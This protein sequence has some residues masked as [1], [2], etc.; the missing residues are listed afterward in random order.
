ML[1]LF[2]Q[3]Y[4]MKHYFTALKQTKRIGV[5]NFKSGFSADELHFLDCLIDKKN[6]SID[7]E[8]VDGKIFATMMDFISIFQNYKP[9]KWEGIDLSIFLPRFWQAFE[10]YGFDFI[11]I[12][13]SQIN[14]YHQ[15]LKETERL[16]VKIQDFEDGFSEEE[17]YLLNCLTNRVE[18]DFSRVQREHIATIANFA[19][20]FE[21]YDVRSWEYVDY[22]IFLPCFWQAYQQ[23]GL[24][25]TNVHTS[26]LTIADLFLRKYHLGISVEHY[27][28]NY[29]DQ[30]NHHEVYDHPSYISWG[31]SLLED[32][33]YS[34]KLYEFPS[35]DEIEDKQFIL[36]FAKEFEMTIDEITSDVEDGI[37][38]G[39]EVITNI[40]IQDVTKIP[41]DLIRLSYSSE[42]KQLYILYEEW[43]NAE[44]RLQL[45]LDILECIEKEEKQNENSNNH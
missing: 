22:S 36:N 3:Q 37:C 5:N 26:Q 18:I 34:S 19:S 41:D 2:E 16:G 40:T 23:H 33:G 6:T 29:L 28:P 42:E 4:R 35:I 8:K 44:H 31:D 32:K 17:I 10:K 13:A 24:A 30:M 39:F 38:N 14:Y 43:F 45:I 15:A 9:M 11:Y 7:I 27:Y 21:E 20:F 25:F 12:E 1:K